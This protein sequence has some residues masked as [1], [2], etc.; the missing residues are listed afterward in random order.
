MG[1]RRKQIHG[2]FSVTAIDVPAGLT[3]DAVAA[4]L[5]ADG[6]AIE[7]PA[8]LL[9]GIFPMLA[10]QAGAPPQAGAGAGEHA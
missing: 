5:P 9:A 4:A 7:L 10:P 1:G 3:A 8:G 6:V 2:F